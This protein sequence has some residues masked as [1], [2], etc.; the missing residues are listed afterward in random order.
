MSHGPAVTLHTDGGSRGNPGPAG[1][2][3]VILDAAGEV[4]AEE[5]VYLGEMTNNQAEYRALVL[6][7]RAAERFAPSAVQVKMDSELI[8]RQMQGL[9]RVRDAGL[10]PLYEEA[11]KLAQALPQVSF[12]HVRRH[13]NRRADALVNRALDAHQ[14]G[15]GGNH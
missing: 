8:V 1:A 12:T 5:G 7:L 2:G 3:Y 15:A 13:L 10:R 9:Y 11:S 4:L 6:G 14:R